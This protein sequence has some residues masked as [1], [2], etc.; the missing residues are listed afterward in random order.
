MLSLGI[1]VIRED[2][3]GQFIKNGPGDYLLGSVKKKAS[4]VRDLTKHA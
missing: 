3:R 1:E 4:M 2:K